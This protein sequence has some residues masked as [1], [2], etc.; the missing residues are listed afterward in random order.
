MHYDTLTYLC[1]CGYDLENNMHYSWKKCCQNIHSRPCSSYPIPVLSSTINLHLSLDK[2]SSRCSS[3]LPPNYLLLLVHIVKLN[4]VWFHL[5]LSKM[6]SHLTYIYMQQLALTH[7]SL[8]TSFTLNRLAQL[9]KLTHHI[10]KNSFLN[11]KNL[12]IGQFL[13]RWIFLVIY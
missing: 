1:S 8:G 12:E 5:G 6:S 10:F 13:M 4:H 9:D 2:Y 3:S 7:L 11:K